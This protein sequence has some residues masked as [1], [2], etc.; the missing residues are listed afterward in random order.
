MRALIN[1]EAALQTK[2][3]INPRGHTHEQQRLT[4]L[5]KRPSNARRHSLVDARAVELEVRVNEM[6]VLCEDLTQECAKVVREVKRSSDLNPDPMGASDDFWPTLVR[7]PASEVLPE[8]CAYMRGLHQA[9]E[10]L[11]KSLGR[12][13]PEDVMRFISRFEVRFTQIRKCCERSTE[14]SA[15]PLAKSTPVS[16]TSAPTLSHMDS[17]FL[18]RSS[19]MIEM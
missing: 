17:M 14:F 19:E 16:R 10:H 8:L 11:S 12:S 5:T 7:A 4:L 18:R 1:F 2:R 15:E 9:L 3:G 13:D 6:I